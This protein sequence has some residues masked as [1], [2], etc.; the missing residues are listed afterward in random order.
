M[1]T[2]AV[3][4]VQWGDEGKG[5]VVDALAARAD[6]VVRYQG[7][8]NAGHTVVV[9]DETFRLSLIP[10]GILYPGTLCL[11]GNGVVIDPFVLAE[12]MAE[13]Q[14]RGVS[15]DGLRISDR[16]HVI[17]PYHRVQDQLEEKA[18]GQAAIG[19]TGSGVGPC[20]VDKAARIGVRMVDFVHPDLLRRRLEEVLPYKN[21][22]LQRM[23]DHPGFELEE[24]VEQCRPVGEE[25]RQ[26]VTDT[27]VLLRQKVDEGRRILF[28]GA[29][30]T[31]LD[32][33]HG[34]YPF[35]TSSSPAAGGISAG[36]GVGPLALR[37]VL[38]IV[39]AYTTRVGGG[40]F[41][42]ELHGPVGDLL[43]KEGHEFGTVTGRPRR[44]GWFDGVAARY[45]ARLN[46]LTSIAVLKLDVLSHVDEVKLA[47]AYR[48]DGETI[49]EFPARLDLLARVEPVWETM[50]GWKTDIRGARRMEDLPA[51]ARAYLRRIEELMEVPISIV[52]VGPRRDETIQLETPW[53]AD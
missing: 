30:G 32:V 46:G 5:K 31:L 52:S 17:L 1:S 12:E 41:P 16:A 34:T 35:V 25:L 11:I 23:Y 47:V 51:E 18:R 36:T 22:L 53:F 28:E 27:G 7:G 38:G 10:S 44:C 24:L 21:R 45:A 33:D 15:L 14:G 20:Y 50:P 3:V 13:L 29:Q 37:H 42:T 8:N 4:G 43:R 39:K 48:M 49:H 9:G 6:V 40:P 26:Y 2:L 19:T